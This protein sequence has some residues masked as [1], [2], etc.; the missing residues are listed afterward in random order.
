MFDG[1]GLFGGMF[2][3]NGDGKIDAVERALEFAVFNEIINNEIIN[4]DSDDD[5]VTDFDRDIDDFDGDIDDF[6][7]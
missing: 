1:K 2:D 6:D 5:D 7:F 3:L 4:E